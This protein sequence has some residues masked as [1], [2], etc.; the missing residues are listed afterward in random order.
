MSAIALFEKYKRRPQGREVHE[1]LLQ[2][3]FCGGGEWL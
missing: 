1:H 2:T 3:V